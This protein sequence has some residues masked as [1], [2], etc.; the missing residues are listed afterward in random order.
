MLSLCPRNPS[1]NWEELDSPT[2]CEGKEAWVKAAGKRILEQREEYQYW[3]NDPYLHLN[4]FDKEEIALNRLKAC[5]RTHAIVNCLHAILSP[6][7]KE[8]PERVEL[9]GVRMDHRMWEPSDPHERVQYLFTYL[10]LLYY[11]LQCFCND[12]DACYDI[13]EQVKT[14][15]LAY[16]T[17]PQNGHLFLQYPSLWEL[18]INPANFKYRLVISLDVLL[19]YSPL[20]YCESCA[21]EL[22]S[23]L[24]YSYATEFY[25]RIHRYMVEARDRKSFHDQMRR[26]IM[27][28]EGP[29]NQFFRLA[30]L[31]TMYRFCSAA[32]RDLNSTFPSRWMHMSTSLK[33]NG[34]FQSVL[35]FCVY[36]GEGDLETFLGRDRKPEL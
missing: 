3:D 6:I 24:H 36:Y 1:T 2:C 27:H 12:D 34:R 7:I 17:D 15:A 14:N 20:D 35:E 25:R 23:A 32:K 30:D 21:D 9:L 19:G 29:G 28:R 16:A 33:R 18:Y 31:E 10:R 22:D 4:V 13:H 8:Q 5:I 11:R 26:N